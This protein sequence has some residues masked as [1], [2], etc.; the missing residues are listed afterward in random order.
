MLCAPIGKKILRYGKCIQS[1]PFSHHLEKGETGKMP[2]ENESYSFLKEQPDQ[3][4][5]GGSVS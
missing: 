1:P 3:G 4:C 5:P 2:T